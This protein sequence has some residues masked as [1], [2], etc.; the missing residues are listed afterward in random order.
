MTKKCNSDY[1]ISDSMKIT[2]SRY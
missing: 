2:D 1:G